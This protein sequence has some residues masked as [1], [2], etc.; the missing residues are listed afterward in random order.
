MNSSPRETLA[1]VEDRVRG[2][3]TDAQL[4]KMLD[5]APTRVAT[6]AK[7]TSPTNQVAKKGPTSTVKQAGTP[8]KSTVATK[9]THKKTSSK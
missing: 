7:S 5:E 6:R 3:A 4:E 2:G 9:A 8:A 1:R